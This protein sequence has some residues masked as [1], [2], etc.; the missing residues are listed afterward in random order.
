MSDARVQ[1][2]ERVRRGESFEVKIL[3]RHPMEP[4]FR[5]TDDGKKLARNV[6]RELRCTYG[7]QEVF[8]VEPSSGI[9]ANP[10]FSFLVIA[11]ESG[12]LIFEWDDDSGTRE[13][14]RA[15]ITV[16]A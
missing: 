10:L 12:E 5:L 7:G 3:I 1:V 14:G 9:A 8:R 15:A 2:P 16:I 11:R 4:G 6:I 13:T